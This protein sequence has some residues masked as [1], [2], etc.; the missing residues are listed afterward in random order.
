[1]IVRL[2]KT[3]MSAQSGMQERDSHHIFW[4]E[5]EH[6]IANQSIDCIGRVAEPCSHTLT[7]VARIK[8]ETV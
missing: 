6:R 8:F 1:M 7:Q 3:E 2:F 5:S 4:S